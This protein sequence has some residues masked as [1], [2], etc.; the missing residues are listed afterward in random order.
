MSGGV[1][2]PSAPPP[3]PRSEPTVGKVTL[4]V[5]LGLVVVAVVELLFR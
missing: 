1:T 5:I 2:S 3:R 4:G